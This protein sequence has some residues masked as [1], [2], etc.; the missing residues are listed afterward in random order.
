MKA[1]S[2]LTSGRAKAYDIEYRERLEVLKNSE[3]MDIVFSE[4][5]HKP[6]T[7]YVGDYS[8]DAMQGSNV[9]LAKWYNKKSVRVEYGE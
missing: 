8:S 1:I 5:V 2:D 3:D 4:Y 9:H 7:V 6:K